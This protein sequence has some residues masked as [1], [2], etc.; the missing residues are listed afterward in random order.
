VR[1]KGGSAL[2]PS[3]DATTNLLIVDIVVRSTA[4]LLRQRIERRVVSASDRD[5]GQA[6]K[7]LKG[8]GAVQTLALYGVSKV[9]TRSPL[10]LGLVAGGLALKTLYDI[11]KS[12]E[13]RPPRGGDDAASDQDKS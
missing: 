13:G 11:G 6:E 1:R 12:R 5:K 7:L 4:R 8:R 10:G 2:L 3:P 9:A